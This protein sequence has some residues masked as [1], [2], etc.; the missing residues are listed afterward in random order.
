MK[1]AAPPPPP[2]FPLLLKQFNFPSE[3]SESEDQL[4]RGFLVRCMTLAPDLRQPLY[5]SLVDHTHL[6]FLHTG[7]L[8]FFFEG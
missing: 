6:A 8:C 5:P 4:G 1:A 2:L 7:Q 3:R